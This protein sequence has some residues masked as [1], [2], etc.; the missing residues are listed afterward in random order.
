MP[1]F[2]QQLISDT[3]ACFKEEDG[4]FLS[5]EEA[6][7]VLESLG[8]LFL[9]FSSDSTSPAPERAFARTGA[10]QAAGVRNT[11]RTLPNTP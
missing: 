7:E 6:V 9:A 4:V 10:G 5:H 3:I 2:S 8:G 11:G 1:K